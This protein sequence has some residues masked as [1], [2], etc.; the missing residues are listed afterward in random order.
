MWATFR[1]KIW[2]ISRG[3]L[4]STT[5]RV[6]NKRNMA[7]ATLLF[8]GTTIGGSSLYLPSVQSRSASRGDPQ[9][10]IG[11][12]L[13]ATSASKNNNISEL[14]TTQMHVRSSTE[15]RTC[16]TNA[17]KHFQQWKKIP[18]PSIMHDN[19]ERL[20]LEERRGTRITSAMEKESSGTHN[21]NI[22][23]IGDVHGCLE[24]LKT[25]VKNATLENNNGKQF[26]AIVLVGDLCNKGPFS[27][28]V[29]RYV[30]NQPRWFSVRGNHDDRALSAALGD[31][32]CCAK[33]KYQWVNKISDEDVNW[34]SNLPYT[35]TIPRTMFHD[36][37]KNANQD[38][39]IVHAGLVPTIGLE[40][41]ETKTMVNVR[42]LMVNDISQAW[43][44]VWQGPELIIFGHDAKRGLQHEEYAIGLDSGCVYGKKLTG[45]IL[46]ERE[47]VSVDAVRDH[48]PIKK[49]A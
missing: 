40:N 26:A 25:L 29:I 47:L 46:P 49:K 44:K 5:S 6:G 27:A 19:L 12:R 35:I 8:L 20:L 10:H 11:N 21:S 4:F 41:Q 22:L 38:T 42:N 18:L 2:S 16:S 13:M 39:I 17:D 9:H 43:A 31:E 1:N 23:V 15:T 14:V 3:A 32:E 45:L 48:C 34:M 7:F 37:A 24:E 33:P 36:D 30:R 28:E